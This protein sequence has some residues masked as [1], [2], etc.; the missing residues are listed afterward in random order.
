MASAK[1]QRS[2]PDKESIEISPSQCGKISREEARKVLDALNSLYGS[3]CALNSKLHK[4]NY[5]V[6]KR[7][8]R[9]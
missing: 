1:Q 8:K 7:N 3:L 2:A 6:Q 9:T 5:L 4:L